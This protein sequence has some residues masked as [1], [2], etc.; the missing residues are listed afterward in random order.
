MN[1]LDLKSIKTYRHNS[2]PEEKL[3]HDNFIEMFYRDGSVRKTL[4]AIV[5]GWS[6]T[7]QNTPEK[8]LSDKEEVVCINIIQWLGSPVGQG[9]LRNC[10]Y[11][12]VSR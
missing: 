4:S 1:K 3:F 11:E 9:F 12:K 5:N 2:N 7:R 6:D 8:Y 10:G